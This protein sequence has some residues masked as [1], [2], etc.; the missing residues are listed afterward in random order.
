MAYVAP[1]GY[2]RFSMKPKPPQ[3]AHRV[4]HEL[5]IGPIPNGLHV[6]HLCR[7][8]HCVN[9]DHLEAVTQ[10]EN[11]LRIPGLGENLILLARAKT[12]CPQGHEYTEENTYW[13]RGHRRCLTCK[14]AHGREWM[15]ANR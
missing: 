5:L 2:G 8:R 13:Y 3:L 6:D 9:P 1:D 10:R 4:A 14:R 15:R 12:H 7:V 11:N